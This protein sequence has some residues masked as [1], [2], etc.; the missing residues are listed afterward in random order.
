MAKARTLEF[1]QIHHMDCLEGM[2]YSPDNSADVVVYIL[3]LREPQQSAYVN[4]RKRD[5]ISS[6]F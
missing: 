1:N 4:K 3:Q 5:I 6:V 2:K